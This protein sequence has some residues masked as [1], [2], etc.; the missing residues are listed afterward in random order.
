MLSEQRYRDLAQSGMKIALVNPS[1]A[2]WSIGTHR[3]F[4][5]FY[6]VFHTYSKKPQ[7]RFS[8]SVPGSNN[9]IKV[10]EKQ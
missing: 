10:I 1:E 9:W 7:R 3:S 6:L 8:L 2:Q 4:M 5:T